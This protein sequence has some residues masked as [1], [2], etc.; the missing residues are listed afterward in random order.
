MIDEELTLPDTGDAPN[1]CGVVDVTNAVDR[2]E[3][4]E[5][6]DGITINR[7]A[8]GKQYTPVEGEWGGD[9]YLVEY[10]MLDLTARSFNPPESSGLEPENYRE[11]LR[12]TG[13]KA[14][15]RH[16]LDPGVDPH[17]ESF[18]RVYRP[19]R[20]DGVECRESAAGTDGDQVTHRV[21]ITPGLLADLDAVRVVRIRYE[22][23]PDGRVENFTATV[24]RVR[25]G[26]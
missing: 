14:G 17:R 7:W 13:I 11:E 5:H 6:D 2:V 19:T 8:G 9:I 25:R 4:D 16:W 12:I 10:S 18:P 22:T 24:R 26:V 20:V 23:S 15:V 3:I 1:D 21:K